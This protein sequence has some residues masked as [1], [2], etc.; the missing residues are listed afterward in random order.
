MFFC[1]QKKLAYGKYLTMQK[2]IALNIIRN[3]YL[4]SLNIEHRVNKKYKLL[5]IFL[6]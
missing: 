5:M 2:I 6:R 1:P 3:F 4:K